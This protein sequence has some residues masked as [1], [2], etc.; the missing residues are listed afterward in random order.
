MALQLNGYPTDE[1]I[2]K[3]RGLHHCR[4]RSRSNKQLTQSKWKKEN[5]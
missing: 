5:H 3:E 2:N 4:P 1:I